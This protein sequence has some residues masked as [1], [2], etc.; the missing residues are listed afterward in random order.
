MWQ[1]PSG[2]ELIILHYHFRPGGV[3]RVIEM[4]APAILRAG[5][6]FRAVVLAAG[7]AP[8]KEW[9]AEFRRL[10][11]PARLEVVTVPAFLYFAGQRGSTAGKER[12]VRAGV[13]RLLGKADQ[14]N[15]LVWAH[16]PG[17][18]RNHLLARE[19]AG[20]CGRTGIPLVLHHHDW[21]FENRWRRWP[22]LQQC[23][24]ATPDDMAETLF[25]KAAT[26]RHA[27]IN[28]ADAKILEKHF[29]SRA[30]WQPNPM[31]RGQTVSAARERSARRWLSG[32]LGDDSPVWIVPCRLLRRKNLCEALLLTRWLRPAAWLVTTGAAS[33]A[34]EEAYANALSD[35]AQTHHWRLRLGILSG[36]GLKKPSVPEL[37]AAS[38]AVLLTSIQEGFGLPALEAAAARRPLIA[39][40]L[41][42]IA[43]DLAEF[44][45]QCPQSYDDILIAP[46]LF[47]AK[48]E[49]RRQRD[50]HGAWLKQMPRSCRAMAAKPDWPARKANPGPVSFSRLTL[51]AQLETLAHPAEDSWRLCSPLNPFLRLWR[52]R[53]ARAELRVTPWPADREKRFGPAAY[54]EQLLKLPDPCASS[55]RSD[56]RAA[57]RE[58]LRDRLKSSAWFPLLSD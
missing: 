51:A 27:A 14:E 17:L 50:L 36:R 6:T 46:E 4:A 54:A 34:D 28:R 20:S 49:V 35:A 52:R 5:K 12:A 1:S 30:I 37:L 42:N 7:E 43:P 41:P 22:E 47:D 57:Q 45:F 19:I 29:G 32:Q 33:S 9:L 23:G 25:P 16:N 39:R 44:G 38:E 11:R 10:V 8:D 40:N 15:T 26:T 56:A 53:A 48:A 58:F 2:L 3:R 31:E 13:K 55:N 18:G 21:W 24:A